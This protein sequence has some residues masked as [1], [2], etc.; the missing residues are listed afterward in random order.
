MI[1]YE[2]LTEYIDGESKKIEQL[3]Q[4]NIPAVGVILEVYGPN[5]HQDMQ[6]NPGGHSVTQA[7]EGLRVDCHGIEGDRHVGLTRSSTAREADLYLRSRAQIVNRRQ[8]FAV[9]PYE[10]VLL[11]KQLGVEVTPQLLGANLLIGRADGGDYCISHVPVNSYLVIA[12]ADAVDASKPPVATLIHYVQQKG[13]S[14]TGKA[15]A[16]AYDDASLSRRFVDH[17]EFER[18]ILC[19]VEYP[20]AEPA[21]LHKGQRVFFKF[22]MGCCY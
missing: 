16:K 1:F 5:D 15:I 7:V 3:K 14:R 19:G 8:V 12:E 22:P 11:S 9:S 18:G 17:A 10:C 13:C 4:A 21:V 20:V 6:Q 2:N